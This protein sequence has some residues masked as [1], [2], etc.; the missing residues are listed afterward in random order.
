MQTLFPQSAKRPKL[1]SEI[2]ELLL[3]T[4]SVMSVSHHRSDL[5]MAQAENREML[6]SVDF[7]KFVTGFTSSQTGAAT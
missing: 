7:A 6:V 5:N 3:Q 4:G 1:G 2:H